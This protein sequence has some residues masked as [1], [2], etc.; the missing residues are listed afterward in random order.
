MSVYSQLRTYSEDVIKPIGKLNGEL[1]YNNQS[2]GPN[3]LGRVI[4]K[5]LQ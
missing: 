5:L 2:L 3:L 1:L 4:L